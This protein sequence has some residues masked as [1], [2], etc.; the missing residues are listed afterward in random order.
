MRTFRVEVHF[1]VYFGAA[2]VC[3]GFSLSLND[4][5]RLPRDGPIDAI[6]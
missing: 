3:V 2:A 1:G 6:L 4:D 5:V